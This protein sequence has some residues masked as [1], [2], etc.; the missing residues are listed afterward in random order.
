MT[1]HIAR[2]IEATREFLRS[3][4]KLHL[5]WPTAIGLTVIRHRSGSIIYGTLDGQRISAT[6][7]AYA[8]GANAYLAADGTLVFQ[9][10]R[11]PI[12]AEARLRAALIERGYVVTNDHDPHTIH[13][14]PGPAAPRSI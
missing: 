14:F 4:D 13:A 12:Q 2:P 7:L 6:R 8:V 10:A 5:D 11:D 3:G 9:S 1:D